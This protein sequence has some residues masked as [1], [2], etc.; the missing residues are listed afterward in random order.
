LI[1][2]VHQTADNKFEKN[3]KNHEEPDYHF[4]QTR[5]T[6]IRAQLHL[7]AS[8]VVQNLCE[9]RTVSG[10]WHQTLGVHQ[11]EQTYP[12]S[13]GQTTQVTTEKII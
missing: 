9:Q 10:L 3:M 12:V 6:M 5:F 13:N 11:A 8:E 1:Q 2:I 4:I 7:G